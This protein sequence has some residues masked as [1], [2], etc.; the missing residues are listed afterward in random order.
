MTSVTKIMTWRRLIATAFTP[1]RHHNLHQQFFRRLGVCGS[2]HAVTVTLKA[3]HMR[4]FCNNN[5]F[6]CVSVQVWCARKVESASGFA[7]F[8]CKCM[9]NGVSFWFCPSNHT[10]ARMRIFYQLTTK[11]MP[12]CGCCAS[13]QTCVLQFYKHT[14][15]RTYIQHIHTYLYIYTTIVFVVAQTHCYFSSPLP[16]WWQFLC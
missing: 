12:W 14:Y 4:H 11:L 1:A 2:L 10:H 5:E 9:Q 7:L 8:H 6:M 3:T 15:I 13:W 16:F